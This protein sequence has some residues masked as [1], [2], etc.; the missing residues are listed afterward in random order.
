MPLYLL[1]LLLGL[2]IALGVLTAVSVLM[3][4][5]PKIDLSARD[6]ARGFKVLV[7]PGL[8]ALWPL[9]VARWIRGSGHP[10]EETN[11]H[12][13]AAAVIDSEARP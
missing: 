3:V 11:A 1:Q 2:Y 13:R 6:G 9:F 5:F 7:F 8:V 10:P 12:R 4:G